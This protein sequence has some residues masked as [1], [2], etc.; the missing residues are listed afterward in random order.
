[1]NYIKETV[2]AMSILL[3]HLSTYVKKMTMTMMIVIVII[4]M[5]VVAA[6]AVAIM[7]IKNMDSYCFLFLVQQAS[8]GQGLIIHEVSRSHTTTHHSR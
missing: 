5:V 6:V 2:T 8:V 4:I 7:M 1:V 3:Q